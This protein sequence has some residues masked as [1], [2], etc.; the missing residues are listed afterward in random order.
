MG[1]VDGSGRV[2]ER[3]RT[4]GAEGWLH[5]GAEDAGTAYWGCQ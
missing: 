2:G 5:D 1:V 3:G 4:D